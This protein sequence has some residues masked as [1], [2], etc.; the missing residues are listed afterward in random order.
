M[1]G[2]R[3]ASNGCSSWDWS[4][5]ARSCRSLERAE[6]HEI[7]GG[8]QAADAWLVGCVEAPPA[9]EQVRGRLA[10]LDT[11]AQI[12]EGEPQDAEAGAWAELRARVAVLRET[13]MALGEALD[14]WERARARRADAG[15][16]NSRRSQLQDD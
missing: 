3:P 1:P 4:S 7:Q 8:V 15:S 10:R 13:L 2:P 5:A 11:Y 12:L 6:C 16:G 14:G 9:A